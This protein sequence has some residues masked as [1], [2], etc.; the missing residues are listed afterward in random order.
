MEDARILNLYFQR[1]EAAIRET[2]DKYGKK[3]HRLSVNITENDHDAEECVSDTYMEAWNRIP[4]TRPDHF[5]AWLARVAR[6]FSY[7]KWE[8]QKAAKRSAQ[9]VSITDE[10]MECIPSGQNPEQVLE[11]KR[12]AML[13]DEFVRGLEPDMQMVFMRRYFWSE[14]IAQISLSTGWTESKLKSMLF[15]MR[16][17]LKQKL[18]K[19][20]FDL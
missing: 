11:A 18:E 3:L 13:M 2:A 19:E 12:L 1:N 9:M 4:P 7:K 6:N 20:D 17:R 8:R 16:K 14:S 15:R 5:F 10:L